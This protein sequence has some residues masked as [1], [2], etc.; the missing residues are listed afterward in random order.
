MKI[1]VDDAGHA[2]L[3]IAMRIHA[4]ANVRLAVLIEMDA[5]YRA[6][7]E[8]DGVSLAENDYTFLALSLS[9]P[10]CK[11]SVTYKSPLDVPLDDVVCEHGNYLLMWTDDEERKLDV[12]N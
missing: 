2:Q 6:K 10:E 12:E 11:C 5:Q 8:E 3:I 9:T 4:P 1:I 7:F